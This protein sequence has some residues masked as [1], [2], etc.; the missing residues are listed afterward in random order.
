MFHAVDKLVVLKTDVFSNL[1]LIFTIES[2]AFFRCIEVMMPL[3]CIL[4]PIQSFFVTVT[5]K[6][7]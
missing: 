6:M 2:A 7:F 5:C 3:S 4:V 1:F